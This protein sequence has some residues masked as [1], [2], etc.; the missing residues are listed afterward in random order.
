[1][2]LRQH[3]REIDGP[4]KPTVAGKT[5]GAIVGS[6]FI[7]EAAGVHVRSHTLDHETRAV[8]PAADGMEMG[9]IP[10]QE[11]VLFAEVLTEAA[12][13]VYVWSRYFKTQ[14]SISQGIS[15]TV[16]ARAVPP[17]EAVDVGVRAVVLEFAAYV[18]VWSRR[19]DGHYLAV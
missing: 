10:P 11:V 18:Y 1:L 8:K 12:S 7:K 3:E 17:P 19:G 14:H 9:A 13:H 16:P 15:Q 2:S 5:V 6:R 4:R